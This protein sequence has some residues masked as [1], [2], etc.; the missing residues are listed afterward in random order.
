M[1]VRQFG[2]DVLGG[3]R[4]NVIRSADVVWRLRSAGVAR[5]AL[6]WLGRACVAALC[7][8]VAITAFLVWVSGHPLAWSVVGCL[9]GAL[10]LAGLLTTVAVWSRAAV[11]AGPSWV[12]V[13]IV[14]RWRVVDL[15]RVRAV[16]LAGGGTA[17]FSGFG[18]GGGARRPGGPGPWGNTGTGGTLIVLE[19][20][21]GAR[22]DLDVAALG[23][24]VADVV[25]QGL[26]A[27]ATIDPDAA[28]VLDRARGHA[29]RAG[30]PPVAD[31]SPAPDGPWDER[32]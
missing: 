11:A 20:D 4:R 16:S 18:S 23:A 21:A 3:R 19:D 14:R 6:R 13:R 24:G 1:R 7:V 30:E 2:P 28:A 31:R 25:A 15:G 32:A 27:D 5:G 26:G 22:I 9:F 8:V 29:P 10:P 12:G 17:G